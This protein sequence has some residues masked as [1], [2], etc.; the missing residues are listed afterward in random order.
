MPVTEMIYVCK[1]LKILRNAS[2][3]YI[4]SVDVIIFPILK[5]L[6]RK[7]FLM[8]LEENMYATFS[9]YTDF[10]CK[11]VFFKMDKPMKYTSVSGILIKTV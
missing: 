8:F 10:S 6:A 2:K 5:D 7:P 11:L 9:T 4:L 1:K 3:F